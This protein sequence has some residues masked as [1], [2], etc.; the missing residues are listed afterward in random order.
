MILVVIHMDKWILWY[1]FN[2]IISKTHETKLSDKS[3]LIV[4]NCVWYT[5]GWSYILHSSI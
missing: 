2:T 4:L 3:I 1:Y 5:D